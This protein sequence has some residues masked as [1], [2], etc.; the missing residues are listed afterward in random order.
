[1]KP[2]EIC[3]VKTRVSNGRFYIVIPLRI[4]GEGVTQWIESLRAYL[5]DFFFIVIIFILFTGVIEILG[6]T[7]SVP[8]ARLTGILIKGF[9]LFFVIQLRRIVDQISH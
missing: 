3:V 4:D 7:V 1:M 2:S 5:P 8:L 9:V 6:I